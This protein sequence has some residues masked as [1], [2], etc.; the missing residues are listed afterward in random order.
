M[1]PINAQNV[2]PLCTRTEKDTLNLC[3]EGAIDLIGRKYN[4]YQFKFFSK[5]QTFSWLN[6]NAILW[7]FCLRS[8][9]LATGCVCTEPCNFYT[10]TSSVSKPTATLHRLCYCKVHIPPRLKRWR[11]QYR[12]LHI[13]YKWKTNIHQHTATTKVTSSTVAYVH[14]DRNFHTDYYS[15]RGSD[16]KD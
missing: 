11:G 8:P 13:I 3:L 9:I 10:T 4:E 15:I 2:R 7:T 1:A 6:K 14:R 12:L 16:H 5:V